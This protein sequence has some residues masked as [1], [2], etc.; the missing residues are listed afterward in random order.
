MNLKKKQKKL[1]SINRKCSHFFGTKYVIFPLLNGVLNKYYTS[2]K[3]VFKFLL[4]SY[5]KL[6]IAEKNWLKQSPCSRKKSQKLV[7]KCEIGKKKN[8]GNNE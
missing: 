1:T 8:K 6:N 5:N 2:E 4:F 3:V 7:T